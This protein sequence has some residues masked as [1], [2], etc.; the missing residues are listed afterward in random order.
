MT[1]GPTDVKVTT[2]A[3]GPDGMPLALRLSEGLGVTAWR[4]AQGNTNNSCGHIRTCTQRRFLVFCTRQQLPRR[5]RPMI[6][7]RRQGYFRKVVASTA[8]QLFLRLQ[9][10]PCTRPLAIVGCRAHKDSPRLTCRLPP[11]LRQSLCRRSDALTS[12]RRWF[13]ILR[14]NCCPVWYEDRRV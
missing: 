12:S 11:G 9:V 3:G 1:T 14:N 4:L 6:W 5:R 8:G 2:A 10:W 13:Y 7:Q